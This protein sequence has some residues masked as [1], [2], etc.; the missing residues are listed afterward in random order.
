M[1]NNNI[2]YLIPTVAILFSAI[3]MGCTSTNQHVPAPISY[4]DRSHGSVNTHGNSISH[5]NNLSHGNNM[6]HQSNLSHGTDIPY[7]SNLSHGN[8]YRDLHHNDTVNRNYDL[9][10]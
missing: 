9:D 5:A 4:N 10:H 7:Q 8:S 1:L 3:L 6:S 2:K